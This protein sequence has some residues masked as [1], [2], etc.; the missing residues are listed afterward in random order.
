MK[1]VNYIMNLTYNVVAS[2]YWN[3][4]LNFRYV[5]I[6]TYLTFNSQLTF[7]F[8]HF[9]KNLRIL[10]MFTSKLIKGRENCVFVG[11]DIINKLV[12]L[13]L[14]KESILGYFWKIFFLQFNG[15]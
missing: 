2:I 15:I 7:P 5:G 1:N 13:V 9:V 11:I 12:F 6:G 10:K 14:S 8:F 4:D 3:I